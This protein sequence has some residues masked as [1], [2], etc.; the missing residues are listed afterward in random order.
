MGITMHQHHQRYRR[1]ISD[2]YDFDQNIYNPSTDD[3]P[4]LPQALRLRIYYFVLWTDIRNLLNPSTAD[5]FLAGFK[6]VSPVRNDLEAEA[7]TTKILGIPCDTAWR[8]NQHPYP[9]SLLIETRLADATFMHNINNLT[10]I[11]IVYQNIKNIKFDALVDLVDMVRSYP[12]LSSA[13]VTSE[14]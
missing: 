3:F 6:D 12:L 2:D 4:S 7:M 10:T 1:S 9:T 13:S 11:E 14:R 8:Y 5:D